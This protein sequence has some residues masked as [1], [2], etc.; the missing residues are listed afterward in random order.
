MKE[1]NALLL[2]YTIF[3]MGFHKKSNPVI[4]FVLTIVIFRN[5]PNKLMIFPGTMITLFGVLPS[6]CFM[7]FRLS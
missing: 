3:I 2:G 5:L 1:Y 7:F 6:N 4:G